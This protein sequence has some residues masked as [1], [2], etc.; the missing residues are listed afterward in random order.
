MTVFVCFERNIGDTSIIEGD[1][2]NMEVFDTEDAAVEWFN[3]RVN[4]GIEQLFV[5]DSEDASYKQ[6]VRDEIEKGFVSLPMYYEREDNIDA[7]Y[8]IR[9]Y[10][11]EIKK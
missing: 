10:K 9:I 5:I 8:E 4:I 6:S 2:S 3:E 7:Y 11:K 1:V